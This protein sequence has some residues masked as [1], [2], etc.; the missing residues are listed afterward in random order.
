[1]SVFAE[2]AC[3]AQGYCPGKY[4]GDYLGEYFGVCNKNPYNFF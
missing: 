2:R 3:P 1:M 4:L